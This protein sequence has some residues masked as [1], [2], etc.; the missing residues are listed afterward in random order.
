MNETQGKDSEYSRDVQL[1]ID[2]IRELESELNKWKAPHEDNELREMKEQ[3]N[4]SS[5]SA[6]QAYINALEWTLKHREAKIKELGE[7]NH[8]L[9]EAIKN[10]VHTGVNF[11]KSIE[12]LQVKNSELEN[13]LNYY[14]KGNAKYYHD[15]TCSAS[16]DKPMGCDGC[17]CE[18]GH[19]LKNLRTRVRELKE[20]IEKHYKE[21]RIG[22]LES[23]G[24]IS[25]SMCRGL[26]EL[27]NL[28]PKKK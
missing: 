11:A 9:R 28:L 20:G 7:D 4:Q 24:S 16:R 19:E 1:G 27:Y 3:T 21:N 26:K 8:N 14:M 17:S 25:I 13:T 12:T 10:E 5:L 15:V 18:I 23:D 22:G 6:K 2:R